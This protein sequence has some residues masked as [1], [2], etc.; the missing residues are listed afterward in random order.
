MMNLKRILAIALSLCMLISLM[1]M[2]TLALAEEVS[3]D[4]SVTVETLGVEKLDSSQIN[5]DLTKTSEEADLALEREAVDEN[6]MV[7]VFIVMEGE[8]IIEEDASAVMDENTQAKVEELEAA[9]A[10]VVSEIEKTVLEG[11]PLEID[12]HYTWLFN[13]VAAEIPYEAIAEIEAV[14]GV[15]EV[16]IQP[17]YEIFETEV[18]NAVP[19]T[20]SDGVMVGRENTWAQGY[21]GMGIK[22]AVID[23]GLDLD[24][25]NFQAL[26][27]DKLTADS[28]TRETVAAVLDKLNASRRMEGLTADAVYHSTKV[29]FG[30]N[31]GDDNT[32]VTH[33]NDGQGDH[34]THVAGIAAANKVAESGVVGVAP[35]A[36]LYIL[37]VFGNQRAGYGMDIVAALEDALILGADVVNMSLGSDAG[38]PSSTSDF[39][40]EIYARVAQTNTV[41]SVSAGN[42]YTSGYENMWGT[43]A[44]LTS[45]PD[46]AVIGEPAV[47]APSMSVASVE[48]WKIQ[49]NYIQVSD[50]YQM[51]YVDNGAQFGQPLLMSL[52]GE[53]GLVAVPGYGAAADF[54]GLDLT[55][56]IALIQRG[57][58][59]FVTKCANAAAAGAVAC[60]VYNNT[61]GE[62]GMDLTDLDAQLPCA[63]ITLADGAY[64]VSALENDPALTVSFPEDTAAIPSILAYQMSEFSSWGVAPD[65]G[66]EPDITAPGGNIYSTID[67]G[68][69]GLMSGTS[70]AAPNIS[71]LSALVMQ[72][73]K[74]NFEGIDYRTMVQNLLMSTSSPLVYGESDLYYSPR[75]Q[76]SGLANAF[77][78]VSTNTYLTVDGCDTPKAELGEDAGR[79]GRYS[80]N[81]NVHNFGTTAAY[82]D[83]DTVVQS[84][85]VADYGGIYFMSSSPVALPAASVENSGNLVLTHDVDN[86]KTTT[87]HDAYLIYQAA[88][89]KAADDS[90]M[91]VAF[92]YDANVSDSV[93]TDDVQA[94]LDALVGNES[95]AHLDDLV[96]EVAAGETAEVN[97][98]VALTEDSKAYLDTYFENGGYVEGYTFLTALNE[99]GVD[100]SLP[101]LAFYGSWDE[102]PI[103]DDGDFW[104]I[105]GVEEAPMVGNQYYN[106]LFTNFQGAASEAYPGMN[107]F[108][109]EPIDMSHI[110]LSPNADG[111]MD[112]VDDIYTSL[113]RNAATLTYRYTNMETDEVYYEQTARN[114]S[115]SVYSAAYGQIIPAIY[116]WFEGEIGLWDWNTDMEGNPVE[117]TNNT[118]LLLEVEATG[119]YEGATA[120]TWAVPITIDLEAP[121]LVSATRN[122]N[123]EDGTVTLEL[124]FKDNLSV[125][126]IALMSGDLTEY[127]A[128]M[129]VED[130]E[131]DENG[132]QNYTATFDITGLNDKLAIVL[133]DYAMNE[134][135]Y[136]L[137]AGGEGT[138]YGEL[139]AYQ[140]NFGTG[141]NSWVS[142]G[143][144][145]NSDEVRIFADEMSIVAAEYVGGYVFAQTET[146]A[147]YGFRYEDMLLDTFK[148]ESTYIAQ[149]DNVYQDLAYSYAEGK[150]YGLYS[151]EEGGYPSSELYSINLKGAYFDE[152]MWMD[153]TPYQEDWVLSRG[154]VYGL[155]LAIDDAGTVYMLGTNYD[156][157]TETTTGNAHL[158]SVGMEYDQW[159]D[160]YMLGYQMNDLGQL[161]QDMDY[162]QSMTWD[163]NTE[164]L[165][166][167]RFN[168]DILDYES[169]LY[170][171]DPEKIETV[172]A[173][174]GTV[175][176]TVYTEK[177]GNLTGETCAMFAPLSDE[178]AAKDVHQ[179]LPEMD[180]SVI[181][182][183]ILRD[184]TVTLNVAGAK[185]L[186][187]DMDPWYTEHKSV[188]W[189]SSDES[190]VVVDQNGNI[191]GVGTGSAIITVANAADETKF[192]TVSVEVTALDLKLEGV[193]TA[194][195]AGMGATA[196]TS[197][198]KFDMVDGIASF[199]IVNPITAPAELD[200]GLSLATSALGRGSMWACEYA[201]TGM[202]Y[203]LDPAT[204][205]VKDAL[206]PVDGDVM[207]GLSYSETLDTFTGIMNMY[208]YVDLELTH[209]EQ[210]AMEDSYDA[211]T[212]SFTY[213]KINMLPY[214]EES[215]TGFVTGESGQGASSEIVFSAVTTLP[216]G[217]YFEDTY[218]DYL[219]G[220]DS[221][222]NAVTYIADQTLL[223]MDNVG[224]LWYIDEICG[225]SKTMEDEY[226]NAEYSNDDGTAYITCYGEFRKGVFAIE[227]EDGTYNFFNIRCID[228]TNLTD[229]FR[230]GSLPRI[231]Y[232]FSDIEYAGTT[233]D[234]AP[235]IIMSLY[236]Y[237]NNGTTNELYLYVPGVGTGEWVMDYETWESYEVKTPTRLYKLGTTG[238]NNIIA[239]VHT[240]EVTGGVDPE[241]SEEEKVEQLGLNTLSVGV[242]TPA[243]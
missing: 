167:A 26:S 166:W 161:P 29:V 179:N 159:S 187:Y 191:L 24:H 215:N 30:F 105:Y 95:A 213:H 58:E 144:D 202:I 165:Y 63:S 53:Y 60:L 148:L 223:L 178:A 132:Y 181:G 124:S 170:I 21:T 14:R 138:P 151:Y 158:W 111:Y 235:M 52:T 109:D 114:V 89:G 222:G 126:V 39:V 103:I 197:T 227:A 201:N 184:D 11:E 85:G 46:N 198:Y 51:G 128:L 7:E 97:V 113:L 47:Y 176:S 86:T 182:T 83:L 67:G 116:S 171:I 100:L 119:A 112:T 57:V 75:S 140:Y 68:E 242:Y 49:R 168:A 239:S 146:G 99:G 19:M 189:T 65:L 210:E 69:Y 37:K 56:K 134:S 72:Y 212:N 243:E 125:S 93:E 127:R 153:Y 224:R 27:E 240:A 32:D 31:Y 193:V 117:L 43:N 145:V 55:G 141:I 4:Q 200:Y 5:V 229:M 203:E 82:Y 195:S 186:V 164:T 205:V 54:E 81:F 133:Y 36:Q 104:E 79:T 33:A 10:K 15:E 98:S 214:L 38:F 35:D 129:P 177:V 73:A 42:N 208:L 175:T 8:S 13:G 225:L 87:S 196:G 108:L 204:G 64:L 160:S 70:M 216:G 221:M 66:L 22:I 41:L 211:E 48:N 241:I 78:S 20:T 185:A 206:L 220:W 40:N 28:A 157:D 162:L 130:V 172:E 136:G 156:W 62:F 137:N 84:E 77:N 192:D 76:G 110:S 142:F 180:S 236:D 118:K 106:L 173:E 120:E 9:Q 209:E 16:I 92:R 115:K 6:G 18:S 231:T 94:Y 91:E 232:H 163:H 147:L 3:I 143:P 219:G 194:Q 155:T 131:P 102:A 96:L 230:E 199:G 226:G 169:E 1:P 90:W 45:N 154:G 207:Y 190:V 71:G 188:V 234:G 217:H 59:S 101:Y 218:K 237:W 122:T 139:V 135:A 228:E 149:L 74:E 233:K 12:Y 61:T 80:Y 50:G 174:D 238:E 123:A 17:I 150:L 44:N 183:P 152:E 25:Q 2:G 88:T 34:G 107:P 121:T 23:T